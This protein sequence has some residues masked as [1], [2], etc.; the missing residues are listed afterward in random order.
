[1][2]KKGLKIDMRKENLYDSA[3]K[4]IFF[5]VFRCPFAKFVGANRIL[6]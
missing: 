4:Q 6:D 5:Y 3:K 2:K 1:M